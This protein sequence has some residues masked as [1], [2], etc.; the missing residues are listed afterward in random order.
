MT[1]D[2]RM[3][4]WGTGGADQAGPM[5]WNWCLN[6]VL[7]GKGWDR[8]VNI[9]DRTSPPRRGSRGGGARDDWK[10]WRPE[11]GVDCTPYGGPREP[12]IRPA[13]RSANGQARSMKLLRISVWQE[14]SL[15]PRHPEIRPKPDTDFRPTSPP[16]AGVGEGGPIIGGQ[17]FPSFRRPAPHSPGSR[18]RSTR[19]L[20]EP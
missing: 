15:H 3:D 14:A 2:F 9:G 8:R 12:W 16:V 4:R 18:L 1:I 5:G 19:A 11:R 7:A 13:T 6:A 20:V 17:R 10:S